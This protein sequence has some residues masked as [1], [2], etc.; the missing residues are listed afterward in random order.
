MP[1]GRPTDY[2]PELAI[3][4]CAEIAIGN[5]LRSI[6]SR[7]DYPSHQTVY[8]WLS[9]YPEFM[10]N[11]ARAKQESADSDADR[12]ESIAEQVLKGEIEPQ[13]ARVAMDAYKWTS[14]KKRPKKYGER[15]TTE[16]TG[17][18]GITDLTEDELDKELRHLESLREQ[19]GHD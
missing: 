16:H 12:I 3:R 6:V 9:K 8:T 19:S 15:I 2:T 14:G 11:Y 7:P 17:S 4:I 1:A 5:S 18:I 10:D 13:A